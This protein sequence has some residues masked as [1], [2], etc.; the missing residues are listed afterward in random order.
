LA[1]P[2]RTRMPKE[3][4][5]VPGTTSISAG[6]TNTKLPIN[7]ELVM[8]GYRQQWQVLPLMASFY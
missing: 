2:R 6:I 8:T 1:K 4:S 7:R 3:T 5:P